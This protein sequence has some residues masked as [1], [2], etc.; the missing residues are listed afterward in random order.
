MATALPK[1]VVM[2]YSTGGVN[3][4]CFTT[5]IVSVISYDGAHKGYLADA[6]GINGLYVDANRDLGCR[7]FMRYRLCSTCRNVINQGNILTDKVLRCNFC[8]I[9]V[10][11]PLTP[12]W[13]WWLDTDM[14]FKFNVLDC[15]LESADPVERPI[16]SALYFGRMNGD[17]LGPVWY[18]RDEKDGRIENLSSFSSGLNRI[19]VCGM[20]CCLI[21]RSVFEKFGDK[22]AHTGFLYF[23]RD[24]APWQPRS[25]MNNDITPFGEDNCFCYRCNQLGIPIYGNADIR[26]NHLKKRYENWDTFME[27]FAHKETD[28][29]GVTH[30]MRRQS[31][32][33]IVEPR[34]RE[35][36][37]SGNARYESGSET[38]HSVGPGE[39]TVHMGGWQHL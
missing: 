4:D 7:R 31:R 1:S 32:E 22:Y 30:R 9:D 28:E 17:N 27:S 20:G 24:T 25:G 37:E 16:I 33:K 26:I 36:G 12:D 14:G 13:L 6:M 3:E 15:L 38:G 29:A 2:F 8:E 23:G 19:G 18:G 34:L 39:T 35:M 11:E 5:S 10:P 21:H